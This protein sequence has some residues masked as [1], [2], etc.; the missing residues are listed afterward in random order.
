VHIAVV[1]GNVSDHFFPLNV[2]ECRKTGRIVLNAIVP[3][4]A[5][6]RTYRVSQKF[7]H[8]A[9]IRVQAKLNRLKINNFRGGLL[10]CTISETPYTCMLN[11]SKVTMVALA[12]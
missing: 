3:S 10:Y 4:D 11:G 12:I 9:L 8:L 6:V 1:V 2:S 5:H 7:S